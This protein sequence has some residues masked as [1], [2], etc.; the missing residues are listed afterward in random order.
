MIYYFN[1]LAY[2]LLS[3]LILGVSTCMITFNSL[4]LKRRNLCSPVS[5]RSQNLQILAGNLT[6]SV[7]SWLVMILISLILYRGS[8]LTWTGFWLALNAFAFMLVGLCLSFLIGYAL[9]SRKPKRPCQSPDLHELHLR[10]VPQLSRR[11]VRVRQLYT[12]YWLVRAD[13]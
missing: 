2:A 4:D 7:G 11:S 12:S 3:I 6:F 5:R 8:M 13:G 1:Y 9:K 10:F